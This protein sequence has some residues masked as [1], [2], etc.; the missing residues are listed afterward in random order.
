MNNENKFDFFS[1]ICDNEVKFEVE[2]VLWRV[3]RFAPDNNLEYL[4][5]QRTYLL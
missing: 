5:G 1:V 2:S 4:H 3:F